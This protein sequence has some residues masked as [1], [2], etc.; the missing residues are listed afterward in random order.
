MPEKK[1]GF[2]C[3]ISVGY[4]DKHQNSRRVCKKLPIFMARRMSIN[5]KFLHTLKR[6]I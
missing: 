2:L 1:G 4:E 5:G 6:L 3:L